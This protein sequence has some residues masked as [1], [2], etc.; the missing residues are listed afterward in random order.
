M[1]PGFLHESEE[2][3]PDKRRAI[4]LIEEYAINDFKSV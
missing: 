4:C 3:V 1:A 2:I